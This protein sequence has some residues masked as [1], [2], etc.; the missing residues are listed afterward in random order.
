MGREDS[1]HSVEEITDKTSEEGKLTTKILKDKG[2]EPLLGPKFGRYALEV[3][4]EFVGVVEFDVRSEWEFTIIR[5]I[6]WTNSKYNTPK[7]WRM[8][9]NNVHDDYDLIGFAVEGEDKILKPPIRGAK[10]VSQNDSCD[11]GKV[12]NTSRYMSTAMGTT[13]GKRNTMCCLHW[14][15][16]LKIVNIK[17]I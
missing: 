1:S 9:F 16:R 15:K 13:W 8:L 5:H 14:K 10:C 17:I 11:Y 2:F 3:D 7:N 6:A 12:Q 4:N